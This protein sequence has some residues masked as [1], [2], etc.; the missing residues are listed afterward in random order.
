MRRSCN[1][2]GCGRDR[3]KH[4]VTEAMVRIRE[5]SRQEAGCD[6]VQ[7]IARGVVSCVP[8]RSISMRCSAGKVPVCKNGEQRE[9]LKNTQDGCRDSRLPAV[10]HTE[11]TEEKGRR[12][13][14]GMSELSNVYSSHHHDT[15]GAT[16]FQ[17]AAAEAADP[18]SQ[19]QE[20]SEGMPT[21]PGQAL[22]KWHGKGK[23]VSAVRGYHQRRGRDHWNQ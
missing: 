12:V 2:A 6:H 15:S 20:T 21:P 1:S 17:D 13:V 10:P 8:S 22:G 19:R 16:E 9:I 23:Y 5:R 11:D 14:L 18:S 7:N 4:N 3:E